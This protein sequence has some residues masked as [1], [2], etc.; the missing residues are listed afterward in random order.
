MVEDEDD[1]ELGGGGEGAD[2]EAEVAQDTDG[3][4]GQHDQ[5]GHVAARII[6]V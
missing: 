1:D 3:G 4:R 2:D 6:D 5:E